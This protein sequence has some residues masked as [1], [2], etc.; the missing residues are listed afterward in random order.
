MSDVLIYSLGFFA[1]SLFGA[2][3]IVQWYK[4]EREG[5]VVSPTC[6]GSLACADLF[7]PDLWCTSKRSN[8]PT[9]PNAIILYLHP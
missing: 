4:S 8:H 1:Q 6:F 5:H 9:W 3:I 7:I 2:R